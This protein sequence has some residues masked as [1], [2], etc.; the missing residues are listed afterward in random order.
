MVKRAISCFGGEKHGPVDERIETIRRALLRVL[1][2]LLCISA[3]AN[4]LRLLKYLLLASAADPRL[5]THHVIE[6]GVYRSQ[7]RCELSRVYRMSP[8]GARVVALDW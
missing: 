7:R 3:H 1:P 6:A 4:T 5:T 8:G 2:V